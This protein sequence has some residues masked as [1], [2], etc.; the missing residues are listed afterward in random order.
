MAKLDNPAA[1][2]SGGY[3]MVTPLFWPRYNF[4]MNPVGRCFSFNE[5]AAGYIRGEGVATFCLKTYVQKVDG[6]W[7]TTD[8]TPLGIC[9]GYRMNSN[10]RNASMQAPN[11][12]AEQDAVLIMLR[13]A[14]ISPL[15]VDAQECFGIGSLLQDAIEVGAA[16]KVYRGTC[17]GVD[18]SFMLGAVK[19]Q[20]A[21]QC[22]VSGHAQIAKAVWSQRWGVNIPTQH[23][24]VLNPHIELEDRPVMIHSEALSYRCRASYHSTATRGFGGTNVNLLFW[25]KATDD[26]ASVTGLRPTFRR[27]TWLAPWQ[28]DNNAINYDGYAGY[29]EDEA[30]Q[31]KDSNQAPAPLIAG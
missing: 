22:E 1:L 27:E 29:E 24:K 9:S 31:S 7:M 10:G 18:E 28:A 20:V 8:Q 12:A 11:A 17:T 15:D 5:D 19:T 13:Q 23:L 26:M 21:A 6:E 14:S 25:V 16:S 3:A 2:A 30:D 4:W